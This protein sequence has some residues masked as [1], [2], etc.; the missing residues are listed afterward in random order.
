MPPRS[1]NI[2]DPT[3]IEEKIQNDDQ[4]EGATGKTRNKKDWVDTAVR[5]SNA[6]RIKY[7]TDHHTVNAKGL[8]LPSSEKIEGS[9][10][11]AKY[12]PL[13]VHS[14]QWTSNAVKKLLRFNEGLSR[15][16]LTNAMSDRARKSVGYYMKRCM[17]DECDAKEGEAPTEANTSKIPLSAMGKL[18]T[19]VAIPLD[20]EPDVI[21]FDVHHYLHEIARRTEAKK[22]L[23]CDSYK[24]ETEKIVA[25]RP[26]TT[27]T[28]KNKS[29]TSGS[30]EEKKTPPV[31]IEKKKS[32]A[33]TK[34]VKN[35]DV[36]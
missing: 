33:T 23:L 35:E 4:E 19:Q 25:I 30:T 32:T 16:I 31:K 18:A 20:F 13:G 12:N 2:E 26:R 10:D 9:R 28:K 5:F 8:Q 1:E 7:L 27:R 24:Q 21:T 34:N 6:R 15:M 36:Y 22:S 17:K 3:L 29:G 14:I 11:E